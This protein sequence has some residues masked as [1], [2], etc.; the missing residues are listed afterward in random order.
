MSCNNLFTQADVTF[1]GWSPNGAYPTSVAELFSWPCIALIYSIPD[2]RHPNLSS[3]L[4][5][6]ALPRPIAF[7][8][9]SV[10]LPLSSL[11]IKFS[12]SLCGMPL[13][14]T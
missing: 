5:C 12:A 3:M 14:A 7:L 11:K 13:Q 6:S 4:D 10:Q 2:K 8:N 9:S 1:K